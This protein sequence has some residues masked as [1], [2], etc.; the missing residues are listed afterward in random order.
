MIT[1]WNVRGLNASE[2]QR[3]VAMFVN[4]D[5]FGLIG[6]LET[7]LTKDRLQLC[8]SKLFS[9]F[10]SLDTCT[11]HPRCRVWAL[12]DPNLYEVQDTAI[13]DSFIH[14]HVRQRCLQ[15]QFWVTFVYAP[16]DYAHRLAL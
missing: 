1:I 4:K 8:H 3:D 9:R 6:L 13:G 10:E 11:F 14:L 12:W 15:K 2:K 5:T 16:N 7:K